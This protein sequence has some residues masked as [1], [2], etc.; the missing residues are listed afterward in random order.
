MARQQ[1]KTSLKA[2]FAKLW[3]REGRV[4]FHGN[5][6]FFSFFLFPRSLA[7]Q[8]LRATRED[9]RKWREEGGNSSCHWRLHVNV[10][11]GILDVYGPMVTTAF[12]C[13][14]SLEMTHTHWDSLFSVNCC[15]GVWQIVFLGCRV[16]RCP[17]SM[18]RDVRILSNGPAYLY[19]AV[20]A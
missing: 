7:G 15:Y 11:H 1:H 18:R 9:A 2:F 3:Q 19:I 17:V 20:W 16:C 13:T 4:K 8:F 6:V 14:A 5:F 12:M 10:T